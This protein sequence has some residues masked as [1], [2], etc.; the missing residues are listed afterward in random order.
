MR[1]KYLKHLDTLHELYIFLIFDFYLKASVV[2]YI[3]VLCF[4]TYSIPYG[5]FCLSFDS[6]NVMHMYKG[7]SVNRSQMNIKCKTC[8]IGTWKKHLFP[9]IPH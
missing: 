7:E 6:W 3:Y 5:H 1:G 4:M 9:D 8:D 2:L